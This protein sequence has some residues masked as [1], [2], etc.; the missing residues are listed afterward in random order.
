VTRKQFFRKKAV[1]TLQ[2]A[3]FRSGLAGV[4]MLEGEGPI[5]S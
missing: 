3:V 1:E 4:T 5:G 2:Q